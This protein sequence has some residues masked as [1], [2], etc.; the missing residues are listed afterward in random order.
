MKSVSVTEM[1]SGVTAS[2]SKT[3]IDLFE[4]AEKLVGNVKK[5]Y[6]EKISE[7]GVDPLRVPESKFSSECLQSATSRIYMDLL[8]YHARNENTFI[9]MFKGW[10]TRF[11]SKNY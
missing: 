6:E 3:P 4:Y 9:K 2:D 7:I 1:N 11:F 8:S 5:R 10:N